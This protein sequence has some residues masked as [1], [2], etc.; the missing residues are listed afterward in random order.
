M[1]DMRVLIAPQEFKGTLTSVAAA[2]AIAEGVRAAIPAAE[3]DV[4]PM[5]DG[6]PGTV[7]VLV[8]ATG[9]QTVSTEVSDPLGRPI[10]AEWGLLPGDTAA[11]EMASAAGLT[12]LKKSERDPRLTT[13]LGVGELI[14]AALD[15]GSREL[16]VGLGGSATNDGGAGLAQALGVRLLDAGGRDLP[17]GGAALARLARIDASGVDARASEA[18]VFAA[19]DVRNPLCGPEGASLIYGPQKGAT[20]AVAEELDRALSHYA[21]VIERELVVSVADV[22]GAGAA[23][24]LGAGLIAFLGAEIRP[25]FQLIAERVGLIDRVRSANLVVTGEGRLDGQ[26]IYGK[27]TVG[28]AELAQAEGIPVIAVVG[29]LGPGWE[30]VQHLFSEIE[31]A[32]DAAHYSLQLP[33]DPAMSARNGTERAVKRWAVS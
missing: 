4:A 3:I 6:G 33:D 30:S 16:I 32:I 15:T 22:P 27:T 24:G 2:E 13:T 28:V 14:T 20:A 12:L 25:G 31:P 19:T 10:V 8:A 7:R 9:G 23:G 26:S 11:I 5:A 17:G 21:K 18:L 29:Q 1:A